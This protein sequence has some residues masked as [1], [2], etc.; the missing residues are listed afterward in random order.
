MQGKDLGVTSWP[1]DHWQTGGGTVWGWISYDP[2]TQSRSTTARPIPAPGT[3]NQ[4]PGDNLWTTT[5]FARD[6]DTGAAKWAYQITPHDLW[7]HDEINESILLDL[8]IDGPDAQGPRP[9]RRATA[10]CTSS[11]APTGEVLS[12]DPYDTVNATKGVDLE[13]RP[14]RSRTRS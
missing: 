11:T 7:D 4:R 8:P 5:I 14:D 3:R 6:P 10:T 1:A 9:Y 2:E 12:A 13:D